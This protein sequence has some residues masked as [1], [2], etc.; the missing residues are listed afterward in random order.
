MKHE[1]L[2]QIADL[3]GKRN[4]LDG[5]IAARI[6]RPMTSGHLGE[7][8]AAEI[9]DVELEQSASA[10][11]WDGHFRSG[12]LQGRSVN[13]K[14]YLRR[15]GILDLTSPLM[16]HE[17]LVMTG[18]AGAAATSHGGTRPWRIDSVYLF[19]AI[20]LRD[21]LLVRGGKVGTASS[22]RAE[23]WAQAEIYPQPVN[24]R[25]RVDEHQVEALK[26]FA[27]AM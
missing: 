6:G 7:W 17:Y 23:L 24:P 27:P 9:F 20:G 13:V 15:E 5:E 18:P 19:D 11:A 22:V 4:R 2:R 3:L 25:L 16:P 1:E 10:A 21:N 8:I 12:P 26:L 14:W